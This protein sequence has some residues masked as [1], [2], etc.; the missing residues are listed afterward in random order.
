VAGPL[1]RCLLQELEDLE[2][3]DVAAAAAAAA[4]VALKLAHERDHF[5]ELGER[6]P[7]SRLGRPMLKEGEHQLF[8][9]VV[10]RVALLDEVTDQRRHELPAARGRRLAGRQEPLQQH[11]DERIALRSDEDRRLAGTPRALDARVAGDLHRPRP[12]GVLAPWADGP[13]AETAATVGGPDHLEEVAGLRAL[14]GLEVAQVTGR[15]SGPCPLDHD[16]RPGPEALEQL[17]DDFFGGAGFRHGRSTLPPLAVPAPSRVPAHFQPPRPLLRWGSMTEYVIRV[18]SRLHQVGAFGSGAARAQSLQMELR[19][20]EPFVA[21]PNHAGINLTLDELWDMQLEEVFLY[22]PD[23][24]G[25]DPVRAQANR[26]FAY[27]LHDFA[28]SNTRPVN[29]GSPLIDRSLET[30]PQAVVITTRRPIVNISGAALL[31]YPAPPADADMALKWR[32]APEFRAYS[33]A[34]FYLDDTAGESLADP[35]TFLARVYD[36]LSN[37]TQAY[38]PD[39]TRIPSCTYAGNDPSTLVWIVAGDIGNSERQIPTTVLANSALHYRYHPS[40]FFR[41]SA[42]RD[43]TILEA[44]TVTEPI[45]ANPGAM[46]IRQIDRAPSHSEW[47]FQLDGEL[48]FGIVAHPAGSDFRRPLDVWRNVIVPLIETGNGEVLLFSQAIAGGVRTFTARELLRGLARCEYARFVQPFDDDPA[49]I[50]AYY[51]QA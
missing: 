14:V 41:R 49:P 27:W 34:T 30:T 3:F 44:A 17:R 24:G 36:E 20:G 47:A 43:L 31:E 9:E 7:L 5:A 22:P 11:L 21:L 26:G 16:P 40:V 37:S 35:T 48:I 45:T 2:Q 8:G 50:W 19:S 15:V 33:Q 1:R 13:D 23:P 4:D 38:L 46:I 32:P 12:S 29:T 18:E 25:G 51:G 28:A 10:G 39:G 6:A 42:T